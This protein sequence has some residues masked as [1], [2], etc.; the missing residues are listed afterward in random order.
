MDASAVLEKLPST[1]PQAQIPVDPNP[2]V[3]IIIPCFNGEA[4]L[5]E[6]LESALAQTYP[7]VEVIVVDDGST[8]RSGEI[9]QAFPVRYLRQ[10]NRGLTPSRNRGIQESRGSC[11]VFLDADDRLKPEA[12]AT[13]LSVLNQHPE[14]AM[15][16]GDHL[17]VDSDGAY[18]SASRKQCLQAAH[19]E[20][21]LGSNFIEMISSV[22]FRKSVFDVVGAFDPHLRVAEDYELYL[23]IA[24]EYPVCC[25]PAVVAEY[26]LHKNN[27]SRNSELMLTMTLDVLESQARFVEGNLRRRAAF[28]GGK[29]RWRKQYGRQL[30]AELARS[31]STLRLNVFLRKLYV[32]ASYYP[33][34]LG[35]LVLLKLMPSL[36]NRTQKKQRGRNPLMEKLREWVSPSKSQTTS[37]VSQAPHAH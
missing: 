8:D 14:C 30:A 5:K 32:L 4:Y 6:T 9:A 3:S 21:L 19:Y 33:Q 29:A 10:E 11:I 22:I 7:H 26:R 25:H 24:R 27:V 17:F 23:R 16:V 12:I 35:M 15:T 13:G 2:L 18:L 1:P 20:A 34:G 36:S 31:F 37:Q 28:V